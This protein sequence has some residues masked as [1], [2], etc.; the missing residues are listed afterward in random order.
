MSEA[1][2]YVYTIDDRLLS[3]LAKQ[4]G[5]NH[6]T[7]DTLMGF[8]RGMMFKILT[9]RGQNYTVDTL[10]RISKFFNVSMEKLCKLEPKANKPIREYSD[11]SKKGKI[12]K[13]NKHDKN[14]RTSNCR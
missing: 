1:T 10:Y 5:L 9:K 13:I 2:K 6:S 12:I 4:K 11:N 8:H 7:L 14:K 3:R